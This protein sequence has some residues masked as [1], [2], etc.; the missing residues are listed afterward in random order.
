MLKQLYIFE[1]WLTFCWPDKLSEK[2]KITKTKN[3]ILALTLAL[4]VLDADVYLQVYIKVLYP[5]KVL[6]FAKLLT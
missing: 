6:F 4:K 2:I 3:V 1:I 5:S